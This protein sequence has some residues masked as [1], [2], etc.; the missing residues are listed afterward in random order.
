MFWMT[1]NRNMIFIENKKKNI[2]NF[3][4]DKLIKVEDKIKEIAEELGWEDI[5][6]FRTDTKEVI[7]FANAKYGC[8]ISYND[9]NEEE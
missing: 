1:R 8:T 4:A 2:N 3:K 5:D 9:D 6:I 7:G